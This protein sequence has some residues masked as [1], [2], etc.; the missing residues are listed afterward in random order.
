MKQ[1]LSSKLLDD[2]QEILNWYLHTL[3]IDDRFEKITDS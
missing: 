3:D 1:S 2:D